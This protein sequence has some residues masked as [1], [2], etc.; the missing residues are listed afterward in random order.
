MPF[1]RRYLG[2][3]TTF[4]TTSNLGW[5]KETLSIFKGHFQELMKLLRNISSTSLPNQSY[6]LGFTIA[7]FG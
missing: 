3:L 7:S 5:N 6:F 1:F 4:K 2:N